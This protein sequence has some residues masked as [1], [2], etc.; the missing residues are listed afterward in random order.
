MATINIVLSDSITP[1]DASITNV[2]EKALSDFLILNEWFNIHLIRANIWTETLP[3]TTIAIPV[4]TLYDRYLFGAVLYGA[5][6]ANVPRTVWRTDDP[7]KQAWTNED[8]HGAQE[9]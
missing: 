5:G 9:V 8:G 7:Q 6:F 2:A 4:P 3:P 1:A